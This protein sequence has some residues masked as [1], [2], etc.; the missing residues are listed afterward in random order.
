MEDINGGYNT[1]RVQI[2][3]D[4]FL[5]IERACQEDSLFAV[6]GSYQSRIYDS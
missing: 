4:E 6:E 5:D 2:E 3:N 1:H